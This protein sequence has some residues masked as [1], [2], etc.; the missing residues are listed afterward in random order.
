MN[1]YHWARN[2]EPLLE[3]SAIHRKDTIS[4][5]VDQTHIQFS[6]QLMQ[7]KNQF[8]SKLIFQC[9]TKKAWLCGF[10]GLPS[11]FIKFLASIAR[12]A[13]FV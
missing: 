5:L 6:R 3:T 7:K 11:Y 13:A 4:S 1:T 10:V 9:L 12:G 2:P 8:F